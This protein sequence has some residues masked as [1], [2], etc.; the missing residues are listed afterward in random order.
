MKK[1]YEK[2][3]RLARQ[4]VFDD[5]KYQK[6]ISFCK[7]KL[8]SSVYTRH[9]AATISKSGIVLSCNAFAVAEKTKNF[10]DYLAKQTAAQQT[11][12]EN[13]FLA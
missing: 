7:Y 2:A 8:D 10:S 1:V 4:K 11:Q 6:I 5:D 3:L 9:E 12:Y 13:Y